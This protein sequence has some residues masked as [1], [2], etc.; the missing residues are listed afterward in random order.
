MRSRGWVARSSTITNAIRPA[1]PAPPAPR[2]SVEDQPASAVWESA[3]TIAPRPVVASAAPRMSKPLQ[4][5]SAA[6]GAMSLRAATAR[7]AGDHP[8]RRPL[9]TVPISAQEQP[10]ERLWR[11]ALR[12]QSG[13]RVRRPRREALQVIAM[14]PADCSSCPP[15][16][17]VNW[18]STCRSGSSR[19]RRRDLPWASAVASRLRVGS[20]RLRGQGPRGRRSS[21]GTDRRR[22]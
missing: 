19:G 15:I 9:E 5:G 16:P 2:T 1:T 7:R 10:S 12:V 17:A 18:T 20:R 8:R 3:K 14:V 21:L 22:S 6:S 11:V 13:R 4:R